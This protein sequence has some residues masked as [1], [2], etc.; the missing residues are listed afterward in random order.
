MKCSIHNVEMKEYSKGN[1][2][3]WSHQ[4]ENGWC[5]GKVKEG[6]YSF[7][8]HLDRIE[9]KIDALLDQPEIVDD[10]QGHVEDKSKNLPF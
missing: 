2:K 1:D 6:R 9:K 3:W 8:A 4:T 5:N 7:K 10:R